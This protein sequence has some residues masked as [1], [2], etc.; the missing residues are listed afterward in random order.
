MNVVIINQHASNKGDRAILTAV[1]RELARNGV[2]A[3]TVSVHDRRFCTIEEIQPGV[4]V[5][6]VPWGWNIERSSDQ[7][8]HRAFYK[9]RNR[10]FRYIAYPIVRRL[11]GSTMRA[12]SRSFLCNAQFY[13]A[14]K[15]ADFV[16][17]TGG[18]HV[19]TLLAPDAISPQIFDMALTL[20]V[21]KKLVLWSQSI[22]PF[23][24]VRPENRD[25]V[26]R[27]LSET[28]LIFVRDNQSLGELSKLGV[29]P[30]RVR[31]TYDSVIGLSDAINSFT[32]PIQ[33]EPI[34]GI[35]VYAAQQR[36]P[37]V[38]TSYV[39]CLAEF[40]DYATEKGYR[41]RFFPMELKG[42]P[43]D[44]RPLIYEI[45][46]SAQHGSR[47]SIE[48]RDLETLEHIAEVAKCRVFVGH[49]THSVIFALISGTPV[50]AIAY[51]SKT[52]DFMRQYE[53]SDFCIPD[54]YLSGDRL[55]FTFGKACTNLNTIARQ[56][57]EKSQRFS[58]IVRRDFQDV[59]DTG[60]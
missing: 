58:E 52:S 34:L 33:R 3:I 16:I 42:S 23:N 38:H 11:V 19:T 56:E 18:H 14:L 27:I 1:L 32:L 60:L 44:D 59:L 53:L 12:G 8:V 37:G 54:D 9:I 45:I 17:S 47:C 25:F 10:W 36:S 7:V 40:I 49:K 21:G 41:P 13:E 31:R 30:H 57:F 4:K 6:F 35:S 29:E 43:G 5:E 55:I 50:I 20:L 51:Q 26:Q 39:R 2:S 22:G 28:T 48:D 46:R 15:E 24:F